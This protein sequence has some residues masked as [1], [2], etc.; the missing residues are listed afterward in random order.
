VL[1]SS[2]RETFPSKVTRES[3]CEG[4]RANLEKLS[5][6]TVDVCEAPGGCITTR[7]FSFPSLVTRYLPHTAHCISMVGLGAWVI[8]AHT[9]TASTARTATPSTAPWPTPPRHLLQE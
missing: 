4:G 7:G 3:P 5:F 2:S 9:A 8:A 1:R 6:I